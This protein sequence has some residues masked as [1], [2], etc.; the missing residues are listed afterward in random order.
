MLLLAVG[1]LYLH[2]YSMNCLL[3]LLTRSSCHLRMLAFASLLA[4]SSIAIS[5]CFRSPRAQP[6]GLAHSDASLQGRMSC[7][8][9]R[10]ELR[11]A[12]PHLVALQQLSTLRICR[13]A[14]YCLLSLRL[15]SHLIVVATRNQLIYRSG[16]K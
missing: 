9:R 14:V 4:S 13:R 7:M 15:N 5:P 12:R 6:C 10:D 1:R 8:S 16:H 2:V 11:L 3:T